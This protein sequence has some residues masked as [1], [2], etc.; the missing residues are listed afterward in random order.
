MNTI[1]KGNI[2]DIINR[3]IKKGYIQIENGIIKDIV[4]TDEVED[5]TFIV[6]GLIDAHVHIESS[7]LPP[8]EF[9]RAAVKHGTVAVVSDPHEIANVMG[10]E[11]VE[12]MIMNARNAPL[13]FFFGVPSCVPAT[14]FETSGAKITAE[15]IEILFKKYDLK[16]LSEMMNY[17]GVIYEDPEVIAKIDIA[18]KLNKR[19]DG[20][21]PGLIG[22]NLQKYASFGISTDHE[23]FTYSEALEKI[24]YGIKVLIREG[25]AAKNFDVLSK[26]IAEHNDMCMFCTD[27]LHPDDLMNGHINL[28]VK[29]ALEMGFDVFDVLSVACLRPVEHYG[30]NVGLLRISDPADMIVVDNLQDFNILRTYVDGKLVFENGVTYFNP[31]FSE[32]LNIFEAERIS[33]ED[34]QI[35][36]RSPKINVIKAIDGELITE[37]IVCEA[38]IENNYVVSDVD[39]DVLKL[40][41]YNR[42]RK[43]KP[44]I[45]FINNFKLKKGAIA[46]TVAH[47]SH[48]IIAV[49]ADDISLIN[50]INA[51][52]E[53]KGGLSVATSA[54]STVLP[55]PIAG[56]MSAMDFESTANL[57]KKLTERAKELGTDLHA[58]FMT[59]SFMALL[60]IPKLKLSDKGLFDGEKFEFIDLFV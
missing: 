3:T 54:E 8:S 26:L 32:K 46:T 30:L 31:T 47:D 19:I 49:G 15:D 53:S 17:P 18:R 59:L 28:L 42:Y 60:V 37:K 6:P 12:Y 16:F 50:A 20:H 7:M 40:V 35:E 4:Y 43:A 36:S 51:I 45:A 5:N 55:L 9:A 11:G 10:I 52:V 39:N 38:K 22:E 2:L 24:K 14:N 48:N 13:K 23:C 27:D 58:P 34:I 33:L 1:L 29:K 21:S 56:L 41:V 57:Y 25:S 44:A